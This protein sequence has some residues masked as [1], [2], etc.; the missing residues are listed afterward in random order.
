MAVITLI[1]IGQKCYRFLR[2]DSIINKGQ[3]V[4]NGLTDCV[5]HMKQAVPV[6]EKESQAGLWDSLVTTL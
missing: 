2:N 5:C 4:N 3:N 1:L 6:L